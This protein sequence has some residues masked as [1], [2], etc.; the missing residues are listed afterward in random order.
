ML[1]AASGARRSG[2]LAAAPTRRRR[3]ASDVEP[4]E[5]SGLPRST[6]G[7]DPVAAE[8]ASADANRKVPIARRR[9]RYPRGGPPCR[10]QFRC[11]AAHRHEIR[12]T[13]DRQHRAPAD[14][15]T[16]DRPLGSPSHRRRSRRS[17]PRLRPARRLG[18]QSYQRGA[19]C[20][21]PARYWHG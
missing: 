21:V 4:G 2:R 15:R 7:E 12:S 3:P 5:P 13:P 8:V 9:R 17:R 14:D 6:T 16:R 11:A 20:A 19:R 10:V 1:S 18:F